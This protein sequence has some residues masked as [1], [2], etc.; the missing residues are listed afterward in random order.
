MF[1][2]SFHNMNTVSL[3]SRLVRDLQALEVARMAPPPTSKLGTNEFRANSANG[4]RVQTHQCRK[5]ISVP[6]K[7][8]NYFSVLMHHV[9]ERDLNGVS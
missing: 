6:P 1:N 4:T 9:R 7:S 3:A 2:D 5:M 8:V